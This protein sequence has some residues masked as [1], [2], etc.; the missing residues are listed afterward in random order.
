M[1]TYF[2]MIFSSLFD[3]FEHPIELSWDCIQA[4][5]SRA[6][7]LVYQQFSFSLELWHLQVFYLRW[8]DLDHR[9]EI[10]SSG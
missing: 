9:A 2:V 1:V 8:Q 6:L 5:H 7:G 3:P 4:A 10:C